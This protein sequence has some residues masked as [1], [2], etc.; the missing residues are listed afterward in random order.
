MAQSKSIAFEELCD[1][2]LNRMRLSHIYQPIMLKTIIAN[3]GSASRE[4]IAKAILLKDRSQIEYYSE[5]VRNMPGRVLSSHGIVIREGQFYQ[6]PEH[7]QNLSA[8]ERQDLISLCDKKLDEYLKKRNDPWSHRRKA[9]SYIPG[10]LRY[11]ILKRSKCRCEACGIS[12]DDKA[13]EVDHI[14]P[15][16]KGGSNDP[17]NLQALCYTCNA[18]KCD[19]DDT[20]FRKVKES[21]STRE[22]GCIFCELATDRVILENEL[23]IAF[24]DQFPVT[25]LHTLI[26]PKRHVASYFDLYAPELN[27]IQ[28]LI[29]GCKRLIMEK[30]KTVQGF[31]VGIN[32]GEVA[33]QSIFHCHVHL[34]PRRKDDSANPRGGVRGVIPQKQSY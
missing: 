16:N 32:V 23:A 29:Q 13:L 14:I 28:T 20:D 34:I 9:S 27:A 12:V 17:S 6:L 21:Y 5:I 18:Q 26:I 24:R 1:F 15:R 30:D 33:G 2:I 25:P 3:G 19:R 11:D 7:L 31:N 8:S 10:T 4:E 22:V